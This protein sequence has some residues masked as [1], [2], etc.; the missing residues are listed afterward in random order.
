VTA[1][2]ESQLLQ[3]KSWQLFCCLCTC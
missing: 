3:C 2:T 1:G